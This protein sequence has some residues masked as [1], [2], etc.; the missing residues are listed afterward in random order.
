[1]LDIRTTN[2]PVQCIALALDSISA[3]G[4]G[5]DY[6]NTPVPAVRCLFDSISMLPKHFGDDVF[7]VLRRGLDEAVEILLCVA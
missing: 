7:K 6:I 3:A 4:F 2:T 1:L 5:S